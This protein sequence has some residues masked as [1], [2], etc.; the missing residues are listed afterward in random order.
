[1]ECSYKVVFKDLTGI[2]WF[3]VYNVLYNVG[4]KNKIETS[5]NVEE[6]LADNRGAK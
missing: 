5:Y 2:W 1:M 3:F 6:H 4:W